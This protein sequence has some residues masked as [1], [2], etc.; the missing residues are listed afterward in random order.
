[1]FG[2]GRVGPN[3]DINQACAKKTV[4]RTAAGL[5]ITPDGFRPA[6][7]PSQGSLVDGTAGGSR[8][9]HS[10]FDLGARTHCQIAKENASNHARLALKARDQ[11]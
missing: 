4:R 11:L 9:S 5:P 3:P 1:M 10:I 6:V 7:S 2:G 8:L